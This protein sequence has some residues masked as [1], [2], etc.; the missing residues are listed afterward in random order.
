MAAPVFFTVEGDYKSVVADTTSDPDIDPDLGPVT[1]SV[2]FTPGLRVGDVILAVTASPRPIGFIAAPIIGRI[3]TDGQV[4]LRADVDL[5]HIPNGDILHFA[6]FGAFPAT[7]NPAKAYVADDT[8]IAYRWTGQ[9]YVDFDPVRLLAQTP[10]LALAGQLVYTVKFEN[11]RFNG[12]SGFIS[13]FVV[14]AKTSD[15]TLNL[16]AE[17][18]VPGTTAAGVTRG[19]PGAPVDAVVRVDDALVFYVEGH[20]LDDPV[21]I[22][23]FVVPPAE[24]NG[25]LP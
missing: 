16:I 23:D 3:D 7:G 10:L 21:D 6:N 13:E 8:D 1:A 22:S 17:G 2:I 12:K 5:S 4:K 15:T 20:A 9:R 25:G 19:L 24:M 14:N 11:V 18:R